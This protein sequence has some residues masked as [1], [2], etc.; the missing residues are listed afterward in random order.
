M[1]VRTILLGGAGVVLAL[2]LNSAQ[3]QTPEGMV[4]GG[5]PAAEKGAPGGGA[6]G[7]SGGM[8]EPKEKPSGPAA[9]ESSP[10]TDSGKAAGK[11]DQMGEGE[12]G[13]AAKDDKAGAEKPTATTG[14]KD[15]SEKAGTA[16]K[17]E[18]KTEGKTGATTSEGK[19][20]ATADTKTDKSA[21]GGKAAKVDA[22]KV[23]THFSQHR[24]NV[25]SVS[26]TEVSVSVGVALPSAIVLYDLPPDIVVVEGGCPIKYF[27]WG[28]DTVVLV[29]S[30]TREVVELIVI[31]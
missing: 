10:G 17:G 2:G 9:T 7:P 12:T 20:G 16:E 3:A 1:N 22:S 19:T 11:A 13:K 5:P 25:K 30:C 21:E 28:D 23:K 29:D 14:G 31:A 4:P 27:L 24:P 26:K 6:G 15:K 18:T 8:M